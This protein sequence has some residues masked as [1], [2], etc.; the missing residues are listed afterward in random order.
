MSEVGPAYLRLSRDA[1]RARAA[2]GGGLARGLLRV[3]A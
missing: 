2:A 3:S 1:L